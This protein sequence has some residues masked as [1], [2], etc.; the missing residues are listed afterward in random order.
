MA[1]LKNVTVND[2]GYVKLP[3]G[4]TL[5]RPGSPTVGMV[6][7]NT[8]LNMVEVYTAGGWRATDDSQSATGGTITTVG[9]WKIHTFTS[10]DSFVPAYTGPVDALIIAGGGSGAPGIGGGGGAGGYIYN[11]GILVTGGNPYPITVGPGGAAGP[12][13]HGPAGSPGTPSTALSITATGGGTG[14]GYYTNPGNNAYPGGSGGG[15]PGY[16]YGSGLRPRSEGIAGQGHPGG[17]GG[18]WPGTPA[19]THYGGGGGGGA[20][21]SGYS[22]SGNWPTSAIDDGKTTWD[23]LLKGNASGGDGAASSISGT[24]T[25][26]AGGGGGGNH[27]PGN[28]YGWATNRGGLGGGGYMTGGN[29]NAATYYGSGGGGAHHPGNEQGGAGYQGI[30]IIRYRAN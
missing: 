11:Q 16:G 8:D 14:V 24:A 17:D 28:A 27:G 26:Y 21:E 12:T 4:T 25:Y 23:P 6:R 15:G 22:R 7:F 10:A 19:G 2:T 18:H 3:T 20:G 13:G 29:G 1:T 30:V 9:G 5:Q